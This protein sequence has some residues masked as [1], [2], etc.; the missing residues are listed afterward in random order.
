M[1][2]AQLELYRAQAEEL[3]H[4]AARTKDE[5]ARWQCE[6]MARAYRVAILVAN[7]Q[8]LPAVIG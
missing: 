4:L 3:E 5:R 1:T 2:R 7:G 6:V 8:D